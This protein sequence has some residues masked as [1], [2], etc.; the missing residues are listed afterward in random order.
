MCI[1]KIFPEA[2]NIKVLI[3]LCIFAK[4]N[5]PIIFNSHILNYTYLSVN[6]LNKLNW[7]V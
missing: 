7:R 6:F 5:S 1:K 4:M 2:G 3:F